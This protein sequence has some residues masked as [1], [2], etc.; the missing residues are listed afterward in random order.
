MLTKIGMDLGYSN[1]TLS[2][3]M[4]EVYRE[5]SVA[6]INNEAKSEADR[7]V[8]FGRAAEDSA[9]GG[10]G[11]KGALVRPFAKGMLHD[12]NLTDGIIRTLVSVVKPA[13]KIR[14]IIG[15]P[16]DCIPKQE[17][18]LFAMLNAAGV[19]SSASVVRSVAAFIGAGYSPISSGISIN[20]GGFSTECAVMH[21]GNILFMKRYDVGGETF[22][23]AVREYIKKNGDVN[24]SLGMAKAIKEKLGAVWKGKE[25]ESIDIEGTLALTGNNIRM[26]VCTEDI[27]GVFE[28]PMQELINCI[29]ETVK[30]VPKEA[31][32]DIMETGIVL[33]GGGAE[34][35]G[36]EVLLE[37][38]LGIKVTKPESPIDSVA[39]GL[40][41][42]NKIVSGK[43]KIDGKNITSQL[44]KL[45]QGSKN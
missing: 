41:V 1:V 45:Y 5:P 37:R 34:L 3:V 17:K 38:V 35:F 14:C 43:N 39:K 27:V 6:L 32:A 21:R 29:V 18:E 30:H 33:T 7:I 2:N 8:S 16:S 42:V 22:D 28:E 11:D 25:N 15:V 20:I 24:I 31:T 9:R 19:Q 40:S 44:A 13:D 12:H 4:S 10:A 26:N 23:R 36:L